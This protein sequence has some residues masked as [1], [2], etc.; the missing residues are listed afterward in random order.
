M[1][2]EGIPDEPSRDRRMGVLPI[3]GPRPIQ[4][5]SGARETVYILGVEPPLS[6]DPAPPS[7]PGSPRERRVLSFD[8]TPV[9]Y[10][11]HPT[12]QNRVVLVVPGFWRS[13]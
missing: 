2:G 7:G 5:E 10:D 6:S 9:S 12:H 8:G 4:T 1:T 13:R 3:S 11:L